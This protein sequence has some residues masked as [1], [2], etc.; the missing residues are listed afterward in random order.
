MTDQIVLGACHC[1]AVHW[2]HVGMPESVTVC[3]CTSCR[4]TA[5]LWAYGHDGEGITIKAGP[6][7]LGAYVSGD[8]MLAVHF[9]T[10]CG[11]VTHWRALEPGPD[12]RRRIAVNMRLAE[13]AEIRAIALQRF[14]GFETWEDQPR[15]GRCVA[16]LWF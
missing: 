13:P 15:D 8:R 3:N 2:S 1:G 6:G 10:T 7:A 4:R 16:D 9:C 14:D 5:A 12:G 11:N